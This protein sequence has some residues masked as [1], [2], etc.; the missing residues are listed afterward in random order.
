MEELKR[1]KVKRGIAINPDTPVSSI[2]NI[3]D[4][5]HLVTVMSV[6]PG[7]AGQ[8]FISQSLASVKELKVIRESRHLNFE[9]EIDGGINLETAKDAVEAGADILVAG[10]YVFKSRNPAKTAASLKKIGQ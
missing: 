8:K 3:L 6:F 5:I 4:Q 9:I 2:I 1:L 10:S 7:F